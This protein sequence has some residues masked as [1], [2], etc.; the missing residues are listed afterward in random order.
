MALEFIAAAEVNDFYPLALKPP[1]NQGQATIHGLASPGDKPQFILDW[2]P[3]IEALLDDLRRGISP[4]VISARFHNALVEAISAVAEVVGESKVA[5]TGGCF[6]NRLLAGRAAQQLSQAGY[7][8]LLHRQVPP[9]D[10]GISLG[11][12]AVAAA[13]LN[14]E[15]ELNIPT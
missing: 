10:G 11:Q 3:L 13:R 4:A 7:E 14:H 12:I 5:L 8:V 6:Q 15:K 9:N 1:D 2:F